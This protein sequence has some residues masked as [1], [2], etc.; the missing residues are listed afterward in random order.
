[1]NLKR[2]LSVL[3]SAILLSSFSSVAYCTEEQP[4]DSTEFSVELEA[5]LSENSKYSTTLEIPDSEEIESDALINTNRLIVSTNS[6]QAL[7][8]TCGAVSCLEGFN[9]WHILQYACEDDTVAAYNFYSS[10][11]YVNYVELDEIIEFQEKAESDTLI[12][13][14]SSD[15]KS[16]S[17]GADRV[18]SLSAISSFKKAKIGSPVVVAVID[19]GV[20]ANH[21]F[22]TDESTK[23]NRILEG[24]RPKDNNP[25]KNQSN[26]IHGTKVAGVIVDNTPSNVK[27]KPYNF[28][29]Y[30]NGT[31]LTLATEIKLAV[32]DNVDV[33]NLSL[34]SE[35]KKD[36]VK[37]AVNSAINQGIVV[38]AAAGNKGIDVYNHYPANFPN[39]ISVAA[40]DSDNKPW[41][42]PENGQKTNYGSSIDISAPGSKIKTTVPGGGY[43]T[44]GGTSMAAPFV[45]AAA[46][47]LKSANKNLTS[48][49]VCEIL[50]SSAYKPSGWASNYASKY[51]AGI[52]NFKNMLKYVTMP[53]PT[54]TLN[55][56]DKI[57]ITSTAGSNAT[58]YYTTDGT[59]PTTS[60]TKYSK[61]FAVPN[62]TK[63]IKAIACVDGIIKSSVAEF[64]VQ[65][66]KYITVRYKG[67]AEFDLPSNAKNIK[68][69]VEDESLVSVED[70]QVYGLKTGET[71]VTVTMNANRIY[72]Y[73]ITVEYVWWQ[74]LIRFLLFGFLWY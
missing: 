35:E 14:Y 36:S 31:T 13:T 23:E 41:Y 5:F 10:Q 56:N 67:K 16:L 3:L 18:E 22:F 15:T 25:D 11:D 6:N 26:Y 20:D 50:T 60:S 54:I 62:N 51:G 53:A 39:V 58:Y 65:V 4:L 19:S 7:E 30:N 70:G 29:Y 34:G 28:Y 38:V 27:I 55:S 73:D 1:M 48:S 37:E 46:A 42:N 49:Q 24:N 12:E 59:T 33:I 44:D 71:T 63:S 43:L 40:F 64:P 72:Y 21:S 68:Y 45:A 69:Y 32:D 57:S 66:H 2:C 17:W 9:N 47:I 74:H 61:S 52:V 8:N